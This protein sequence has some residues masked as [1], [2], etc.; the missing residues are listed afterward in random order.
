MT[1]YRATSEIERCVLCY[2]SQKNILGQRKIDAVHP[3]ILFAMPA[4]VFF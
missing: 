3:A 4:G 1:A 2:W